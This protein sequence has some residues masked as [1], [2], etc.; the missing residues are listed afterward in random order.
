[1]PVADSVGYLT[2][3]G[4]EVELASQGGTRRVRVEEFHQGYKKTAI[5]PDEI[6]TRVL[7]PLPGRDELLRLY[8]VSKRRE[9]DMTTFRA[10]IR[11]ARRG[12]TIDRAVLAYSGVGPV[13]RRLPR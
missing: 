5:R 6:I 9:M 8:K 3:T 2:V 7:I 11:V 10:A 4:A 13:T 1:S 12:G